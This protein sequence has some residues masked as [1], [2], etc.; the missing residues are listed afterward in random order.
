MYDPRTNQYTFYQCRYYNDVFA[1]MIDAD[2]PTSQTKDKQK[3]RI[4]K[5]QIIAELNNS[6]KGNRPYKGRLTLT[7][8]ISGTQKYIQR[9][10]ID[11]LLKIL[12][13]TLKG[14]VFIDDKQIWSVMASKQIQAQNGFFVGIRE[15]A[16]GEINLAIPPLYSENPLSG[17]EEGKTTMWRAVED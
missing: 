15:L 11:N 9:V 14:R 4:F 12:F 17:I 2:I 3:K 10:D 1:F 16:E 6:Q 13:D 7:I 8:S 5:E